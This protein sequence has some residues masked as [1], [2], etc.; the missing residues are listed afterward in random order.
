MK[1]L[2]AEDDDYLSEAITTA[3][4]H[5]GYHVDRVVTAL[6]AKGALV[7]V[8]YDLLLLDLGLP[9]QDGTKLLKDIRQEGRAIP[10]MIITARD[11]IEDKISG[12]D[13]GA[14][15]YLTKPFD[16]RE[17]ESRIRALLRKSVW[18]NSECFKL[19]RLSFNTGTREVFLDEKLVRLTP[20]ELTV[21]EAL[22]KKVGRIVNKAELID[23]IARWDESASENAVEILVHR[24]RKKL[25]PGEVKIQTVRGL[26]YIIE[27]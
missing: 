4:K 23:Y 26:G 13:Q 6:E 24:L 3:L 17:L 5:G 19:G 11:T 15:D 18:G 22:L 1:I 2:V 14:N 7:A 12:L 10:V 21:L 20:G 27:K 9:D 25:E 16:F 8:P